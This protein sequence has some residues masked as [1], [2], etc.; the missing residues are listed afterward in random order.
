MSPRVLM[1]ICR[2][3]ITIFI[4][5]NKN[6]CKKEKTFEYIVVFTFRKFTKTLLTHFFTDREQV[7]VV[8]K[9]TFY[10]IKRSSLYEGSILLTDRCKFSF[11]FCSNFDSPSDL[12][13]IVKNWITT[14]LSL[15]LQELVGQKLPPT[16]R[17]IR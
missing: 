2:L 15:Y 13:Y 10:R 11:Y 17:K 7:S 4:C 5:I 16:S 3:D 6:D 14:I 9:D 8:C 12:C 1:Y